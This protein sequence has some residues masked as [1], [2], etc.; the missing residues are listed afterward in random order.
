MILK[1]LKDFFLLGLVFAFCSAHGL[2][3]EI[4][5]GDSQPD[6]IAVV[7]FFDK[8]G[9]N[10]PTGTEISTIVKNDLDLSGLFSLVDQ[11]T[12]LEKPQTL[13]TKGHN[14]KNWKPLAARF[15]VYG[16]IKESGTE[17]TI[18]FNLVD[19]VAGS[20]MLSMNVSGNEKKLRKTAHV[21]ADY[22]Y[23]RV[24]NE[25]GY[26]NTH[27][28]VVESASK[29]GIKRKTRL[30]RMD[31]DGYDPVGLTDGSEL[32]LMARYANDGKTIAFISYSDQGKDI[33]GKSAHIYTINLQTERKN[34][35]INRNMMKELIKK[36]NGNPIQMTYAPRF[37][38]DAT[39]AV[40]A[41][42]IDGKS[43]IYTLD[44]PKNELKQLT[45]HEYNSKGES[46]IDT[47]PC[48]SNDDSKIVFTSNR[49]GTE[50][51]YIMDADGSNQ[52]RISKEG[53]KYS[54]PVWSPRGDFIAFAK[55]T[56]RKFFIGLMKPDG[57]SERLI[58]S[59]YLAE[60][61]C[62]ASNGRYIAYSCQADKS[63]KNKIGVVDITGNHVRIIESRG[64]AAYPA[65]SPP[66]LVTRR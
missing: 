51:I 1:N 8:D 5:K 3:I 4:N 59:A 12:F 58:T 62:W 48:F 53:G 49:E 66:L 64:D 61:P 2:K 57:S 29:A 19:I 65:W 11:S 18:S 15:L 38:K 54:Q 7:D 60:A 56:E 52:H 24:T 13:A 34:L 26:F 22:I 40:L 23:E 44:I 39:K 47:S 32:V 14:I 9:R 28:I 17:F 20:V 43:A 41:I 46:R 16:S 37:S 55:M 45:K 31:Q 27:I 25:D 42:I 35:L 6:P 63:Q 30:V 36:N 21:I 50:A 10:N 33:L